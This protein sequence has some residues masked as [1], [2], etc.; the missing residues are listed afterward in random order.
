MKRIKATNSIRLVKVLKEY[1]WAIKQPQKD[2]A[3]E[4]G[5]SATSVSQFEHN[6]NIPSGEIMAK[7]LRWLLEDIPEEQEDVEDEG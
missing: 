7:M 2:F 4:L 3:D 6:H 5:I 1:R